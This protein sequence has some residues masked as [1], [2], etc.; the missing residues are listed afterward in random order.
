MLPHLDQ[1]C[2]IVAE[3]RHVTTCSNTAI[4]P[5][6][7]CTNDATAAKKK[8]AFIIYVSGAFLRSSGSFNSPFIRR[9]GAWCISWC[10]LLYS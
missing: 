7:I 5:F 9:F 4:H 8:L 3:V 2:V 6:R 10:P 1:K